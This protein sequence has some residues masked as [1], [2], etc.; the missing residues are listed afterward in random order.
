MRTLIL[1]FLLLLFG[2]SYGF[3]QSDSLRRIQMIDSI[4]QSQSSKP[5]EAK[6][7]PR[8]ATWLSV[9]VPGAGQV[10]NKKY[11]KA[12]V[13]YAGFAGFGYFAYLNNKYYQ[14]FKEAY[15]DFERPYVAMGNPAPSSGSITVD[16]V[17]GYHPTRVLEARNYY[18]RWRDMNFIFLGFWYMLNI[19]DAN[20]D[21]HFFDYDVGD[22]LSF[23][24]T[25]DMKVDQ[26]GTA[27]LGTKLTFRF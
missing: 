15:A 20:V 10:Y 1:S 18:R 25:P 8:L 14:Q 24:W 6:H 16:G 9:A 27:S 19:V 11:W 17:A 13:I 21:G 5:Q 23:H 7:N 3:S 12:P 26:F 4:T 2:V 22:D